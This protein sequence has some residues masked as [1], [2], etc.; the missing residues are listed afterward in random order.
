MGTTLAPSSCHRAPLATAK[1]TST[2]DSSTPVW[3]FHTGVEESKVEMHGVETANLVFDH[4][5]VEETL[6]E[7]TLEWLVSTVET[8]ELE[9]F[10]MYLL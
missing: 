2:F 10:I 6:G 3:N 9:Y 4:F 8:A 7:K 5:S 1:V